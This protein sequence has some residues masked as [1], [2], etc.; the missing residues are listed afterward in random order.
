MTPAS[1]PRGAHPRVLL[2]AAA[3]Q[4]GPA[5]VVAWC[6]RLASGEDRATDPDLAWLGGSEDW[7]A[8]WRRVWGARGLLY[9]WDDSAGVV[10][11]LAAAVGDEHWRVREM[12]LK[13]VRARRLQQLD[14][15]VVAA[16][17][18]GHPRV[19]AAATRALAALDRG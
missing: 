16:L 17:A 5:Q 8:Y 1:P 15:Q 13:V 3:E 9:V 12:A 11:A 19:R 14:S 7:P 18:D 2:A 6:C 4:L 10:A